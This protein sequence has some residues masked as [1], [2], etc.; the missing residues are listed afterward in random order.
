MFLLKVQLS[1][2]REKRR[3]T[4]EISAL[5]SAVL[6]QKEQRRAIVKKIS[7]AAVLC[8]LPDAQKQE[9][10]RVLSL[11]PQYRRR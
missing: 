8:L 5:H 3:N 11:E 7:R 10:P 6:S 9:A 2:T 4:N 1:A